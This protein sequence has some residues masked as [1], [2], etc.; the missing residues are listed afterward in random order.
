LTDSLPRRAENYA[1]VDYPADRFRKLMG[2][3]V[4]GS[5][6]CAREAAKD[7]MKRNA[8]GSIVLIGSMSGA[9]VSASPFPSSRRYILSY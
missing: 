9:A 6:Y 8:K 1:A 7:M 3:N 4:E 5:F 2:I